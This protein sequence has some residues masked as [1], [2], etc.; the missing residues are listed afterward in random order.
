MLQWT[1]LESRNR[2]TDR[3]NGPMDSGREGGGGGARREE[4]GWIERLGLTYIHY[5]V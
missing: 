1:Y 2:D 3:E 4:V 5:Y